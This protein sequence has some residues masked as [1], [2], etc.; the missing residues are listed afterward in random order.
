ML[1]EVPLAGDGTARKPHVVDLPPDRTRVIKET[2]HF[3]CDQLTVR[4]VG[5]K[6][7]LGRRGSVSIVVAPTLQTEYFR[8]KARL[9]V[10]L[11]S[12]GKIV[13]SWQDNLTLGL[14]AA[15]VIGGGAL[16]MA[17]PKKSRTPEAVFEFV[18]EEELH[19]LVGGPDAKVRLVVEIEGEPEEEED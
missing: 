14:T 19:R 10:S 18:S 13:K 6:K 17:S 4:Q 15:D 12:D 5:L 8:Q 11:I 7:R 2:A 3:V 9:A 1:L 16:G